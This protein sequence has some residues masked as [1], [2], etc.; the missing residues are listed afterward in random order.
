MPIVGRRSRIPSFA[1]AY[2]IGSALAAPALVGPAGTRR[3]PRTSTASGSPIT[4]GLLLEAQHAWL[5]G[6]SADAERRY[7]RCRSLFPEQVEPWFLSA[8]LLFQQ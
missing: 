3:R 1:L 4:I 7:A 5:H 6:H 8:I 2:P